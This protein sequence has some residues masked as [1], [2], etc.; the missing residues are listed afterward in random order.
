[1]T[2]KTLQDR[3]RDEAMIADE[4][5]YY[6][7]A[8]SLVQAADALDAQAARIKELEGA[9]LTIIEWHDRPIGP[10][11][12]FSDAAKRLDAL[13]DRARESLTAAAIRRG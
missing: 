10:D 6:N 3:L 8:R 7:H 11:E 9:L 13:I 5:Q 1:M 12:L 2:D 4:H